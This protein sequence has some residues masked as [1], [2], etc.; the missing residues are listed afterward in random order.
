MNM[1]HESECEAG[2]NI[3]EEQINASPARQLF[4]YLLL[5]VAV[6]Q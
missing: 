5:G 4:P 2:I 6:H 3:D 1:L